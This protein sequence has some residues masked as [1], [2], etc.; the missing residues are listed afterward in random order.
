MAKT[1]CAAAVEAAHLGPGS[2]RAHVL[3][4]CRATQ[5]HVPPARA[6]TGSWSSRATD[7]RLDRDASHVTL[8]S[9]PAPLLLDR[10]RGDPEAGARSGNRENELLR[11][12]ENS[13]RNSR[14]RS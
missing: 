5:A 6:P 7:D 12:N 9:V 2:R 1:R 4:F 10:L 14:L 13:S 11:E 8:S 3:N